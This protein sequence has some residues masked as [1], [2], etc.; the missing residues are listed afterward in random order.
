MFD[1]H[2]DAL[3][4]VE[5]PKTDAETI[6]NAIKDFMLPFQ[7]PLGQCRGPAYDGASN[8]SGHISGVAARLQKDEPTTIYVHC[9]G[10]SLNLCLQTLARH[11]LPIRE[12]LELAKELGI[13]IDL[14]PK[15][16][17][18]FEKQQL[19]PEAPSIR[20]LCPTRWTVHAQALEAKRATKPY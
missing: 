6:A 4:L 5:L 10:H 7:L 8:M 9:F 16:S 19:T 17:H 3:E 18:M 1:I 12:A 11:V 13:F 14:S 2:E 15:R 20:M